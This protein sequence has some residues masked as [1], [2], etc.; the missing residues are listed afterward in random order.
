MIS[1]DVSAGL[2]NPSVL[3]VFTDGGILTPETALKDATCDRLA[4]DDGSIA[5]ATVRHSGRGRRDS[6]WFSAA[7]L[8]TGAAGGGCLSTIFQC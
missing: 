6:A 5:H 7:N 3:R 4:T 8:I 1:K 2:E